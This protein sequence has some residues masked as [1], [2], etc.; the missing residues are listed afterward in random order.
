MYG[1]I[2]MT[3]AQWKRSRAALDKARELIGS[4]AAIADR[5]TH[6]GRPIT[7]Q[8]VRLWNVRGI[9]T[10]WVLRLERATGH[11]VMRWDLRPDFY[12]RPKRKGG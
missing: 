1:H 3:P 9:P 10:H 12:P 11:R 7:R 8:G 4:Y 6:Q 2:E 5:L